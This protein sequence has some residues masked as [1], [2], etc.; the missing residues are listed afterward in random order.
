VSRLRMSRKISSPPCRLHD[1]SGTALLL[2]DILFVSTD[3]E[4]GV[5]VVENGVMKRILVR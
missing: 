4:H 5:R 3:T 1:G 2:H